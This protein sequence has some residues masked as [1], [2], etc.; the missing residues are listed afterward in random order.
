MSSAAGLR[1]QRLRLYA[2]QDGGSDGYVATYFLFTVERWGRIGSSRSLSQ[3]PSTGG[4]GPG[5]RQQMRTDAVAEFAFEVGPEVPM[6]GII[7]DPDGTLWWVRGV[8]QRRQ[9][10]RTLVGVDRVTPEEA[11]TFLLQDDP[12]PLGGVHV[13]EPPA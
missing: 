1:D 3:A 2:R 13:V 5:E 11:T 9:T 8:D 6:A 4:G 10:R 7:R 12:S